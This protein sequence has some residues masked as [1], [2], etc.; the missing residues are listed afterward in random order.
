MRVLNMCQLIRKKKESANLIRNS[1]VSTDFLSPAILYE[2][3]KQICRR[4]NCCF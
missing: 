1:D 3:I 4:L 2:K